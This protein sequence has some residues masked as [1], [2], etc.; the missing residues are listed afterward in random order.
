MSSVV[1]ED[2]AMGDIPERL[3]ST[4]GELLEASLAPATHTLYER[5]WNK[6]V[7]FGKHQRFDSGVHARR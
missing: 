1:A 2:P 5:A 4:V 3:R 6:L 7:T